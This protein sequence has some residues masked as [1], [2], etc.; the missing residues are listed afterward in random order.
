MALYNT[1]WKKMIKDTSNPYIHPSL[2]NTLELVKR[3]RGVEQNE[4]YDT[5]SYLYDAREHITQSPSP[6]QAVT[7]DKLTA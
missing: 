7:S 4:E 2:I 1:R 6:Y 3:Q 5:P